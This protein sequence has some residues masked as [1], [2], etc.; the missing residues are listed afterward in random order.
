MEIATDWI[1][2]WRELVEAKTRSR[3][4][5][6]RAR[7]REDD[8]WKTKARSF[9][10]KLRERW[11]EPDSSRRTV[12]S[13][14]QAVPGATVLDIGVGT[15][16][17]ACLLARH[18]RSVT[19]VEPSPTMIEVTEENM[20]A[21]GMRNVQIVQGSWPD[22]S[23]ASYD[24]SLCSHA[25]YGYPDLPAFVRRMMEVT[26]R[27]CFLVMR[28]PLADGL[29][30]KAA[31]RIWGQPHDSPNFQV[32]YNAM[33][34]MGLFPNVLMEDI[35]LWRPSTSASLEEA[36]AEVKRKFGLGTP[37]EHD[38]FLEELLSRRLTWR[39]GQYEWPSG[40]RSALVSWDV[41][42]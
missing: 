3:A 41:A 26:R 24:F 7:G 34:Q 23:V 22:V 4:A 36:L 18:A 19:A 12:I 30:A 5:K 10:A 11:A 40:V 21:E 17:W 29:M 27:T 13:A 42:D 20:A 15:G 8:V 25:M 16:A 1:R 33:L 2:L 32:A 6:S 37:S 35:G 31:M 14:L 28:A 9:D 38:V 39:N